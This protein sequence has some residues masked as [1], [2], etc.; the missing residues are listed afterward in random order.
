MLNW[1]EGSDVGMSDS[2]V[3]ELREQNY[4]LGLHVAKLRVRLGY[5]DCEAS[6]RTVYAENLSRFVVIAECRFPCV[7]CSKPQGAQHD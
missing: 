3:D 4:V 2:E 7:D 5:A 6:A 1:S